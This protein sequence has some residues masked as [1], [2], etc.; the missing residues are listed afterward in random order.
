MFT[1]LPI[2]ELPITELPIMELPFKLEKIEL[3]FARS[4]SK[5]DA[6]KMRRQMPK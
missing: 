6:V 3:K 2:T 1:E 4:E 5:F